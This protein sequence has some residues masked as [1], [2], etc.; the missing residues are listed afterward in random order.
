MNVYLNYPPQVENMYTIANT[1]WM[2]CVSTKINP[3]ATEDLE[4]MYNG[5]VCI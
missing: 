2:I 4:N 5:C 3:V 1:V